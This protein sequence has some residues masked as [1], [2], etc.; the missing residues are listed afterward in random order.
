MGTKDAIINIKNKYRSEGLYAA[1]K[2]SKFL[3]LINFYKK[4]WHKF[5]NPSLYEL[6]Q[7]ADKQTINFLS[8][9]KK[10]NTDQYNSEFQKVFGRFNQIRKNAKLNY[11]QDFGINEFEAKF[12]YGVVRKTRP[13]IFVETGVANGDS[14]FFILSAIK[15]NK[16]GKLIS[17]EVNNDVGNLVP[18]DLRKA[19]ELKILRRNFP[20]NFKSILSSLPNVDIFLHD[21]DHSY[22]WQM[23]EYTNALNK[24]SKK[25]LLL[26]DD[27]DSSYALIDLIKANPNKYKVFTIVTN[28]KVF[29][30]IRK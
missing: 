28:R 11:P 9:S 14:S 30:I 29:G 3:I 24:L 20:N 17:I 4:V 16:I 6:Y 15:K 22:T 23:L 21:S 5:I 13:E 8:L 7:I 27:I 10:F 18:K 1:I 12:L 26:S 19:W 25:G 2:Y